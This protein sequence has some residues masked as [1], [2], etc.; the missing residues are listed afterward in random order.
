[1]FKTMTAAAILLAAA[2]SAPAHAAVE[3][4][5]REA[6]EAMDR[7]NPGGAIWF[8]SICETA[9]QRY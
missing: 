5:G 8:D 9:R 6:Q 7:I 2:C 3:L 1:M 4:T